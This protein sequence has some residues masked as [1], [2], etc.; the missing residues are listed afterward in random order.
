MHILMHINFLKVGR[1]D[2][3]KLHAIAS[4]FTNSGDN[5]ERVQRWLG[6]VFQDV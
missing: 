1:R 6:V 4:L 2:G 3:E 5:G